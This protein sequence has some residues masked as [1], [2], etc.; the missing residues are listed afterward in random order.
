M[1][2]YPMKKNFEDLNIVAREC[3]RL[4]RVER[5]PQA[6]IEITQHI[7]DSIDQRE[8]RDGFDRILCTHGAALRQLGKIIKSLEFAEH[9]I[10]ENPNRKHPFNLAGAACFDLGQF[11]RGIEYF[12]MAREKGATDEEVSRIMASAKK[13]YKNARKGVYT[14]EYG[15]NGEFDS[16]LFAEEWA[17]E[18]ELLNEELDDY[19]NSMEASL[20]DGWFYR[21]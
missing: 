11:D 2:K 16:E 13:R 3:A 20:E 12:E 5:N 4:R 10:S 7:I 14:Y 18:M 1:S 17:E 15:E 8:S 6:V 9:S 21:D 19:K